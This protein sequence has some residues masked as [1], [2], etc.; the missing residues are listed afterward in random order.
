MSIEQQN[1]DRLM[2][3]ALG[4]HDFC[5]GYKPLDNQSE[6]YYNGYADA[7]KKERRLADE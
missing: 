5:L 6:H 4:E 7:E 1:R 3:Y 2:D